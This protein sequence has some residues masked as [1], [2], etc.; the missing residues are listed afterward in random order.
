MNFS[1]FDNPTKNL[2]SNNHLKNVNIF[3]YKII[4]GFQKFAKAVHI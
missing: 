2:S 1:N 4:T 3:L